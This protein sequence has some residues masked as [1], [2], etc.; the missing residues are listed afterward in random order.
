MYSRK[1]ILQAAFFLILAGM[2][3]SGYLLKPTDVRI[4]HYYES[5]SMYKEAIA[6]YEES[7]ENT[8][9][10]DFQEE[11]LVRISILC[12][13]IEDYEKF[14]IT[15]KRL[16]DLEYDDPKLMMD[17]AHIARDF[18]HFD[19]TNKKK[20]DDV[21][22]FAKRSGN[23]NFVMDFLLGNQR[24]GEA[25]SLYDEAYSSG[26]FTEEEMRKA[27]T[28]AR[29]TGDLQKRKMWLERALD[30]IGDVEV[31][32]ELFVVSVASGDNET[33]LQ[34][35]SHMQP[36]TLD[37]F[38]VLADFYDD[39]EDKQRAKACYAKAEALCV[40]ELA[41]IED[42]TSDRS[43]K[44]LTELVYLYWKNEKFEAVVSV[45]EDLRAMGCKDKKLMDDA[46]NA[47]LHLWR[48]NPD[49]RENQERIIRI[50][51]DMGKDDF[52]LD[53]LVQN[54]RVLDAL[55][56]YEKRRQKGELS[57]DDLKTAMEIA[58]WQNDQTVRE[59]WFERGINELPLDLKDKAFMDGAFQTSL[60]LWHENPNNRKNQERVIRIAEN[61]GKED[62]LPDFFVWNKRYSDALNIYEQRWEKGALAPNGLKKAIEISYW[63]N[64]R[65]LQKKWLKRGA[66]ELSDPE[67]MNKL[68]YMY[69][70]DG[71]YQPA[72][73]LY[74]RL[75]EIEPS[76]K[77]Y[78][79]KLA[80]LSETERDYR[81][82]YD[83]YKKAYNE[84]K[85][86]TY[87]Q[88]M[89][90]CAYHLDQS[91]YEDALQESV[92]LNPTEEN[93]FRLAS[94]YL[95]VK[96]DYR[97]ANKVLEKMVREWPLPKYQVLLSYS[98]L[99]FGDNSAALDILKRIPPEFN[100]PWGIQ[101]LSKHYQEQGKW[102]KAIDVIKD[103]I[104]FHPDD[105]DT[106][107]CLAYI[108]KRLNWT[109]K[110]QELIQSLLPSE[111]TEQMNK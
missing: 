61:M 110:Y 68:A 1:H 56:I 74:L 87:L 5:L 81:T 93:L 7:L 72:K 55:K 22:L 29:W 59:R 103:Y 40:Q 71:E 42:K 64:N 91:I 105:T 23:R 17:G 39:I 79:V 111:G 20:Q 78:L 31:I 89:V 92:E 30:V 36:K 25:L 62:Y 9:D 13:Y 35:A 6:A 101:F 107:L 50:A 96:K 73:R 49:N 16:L 21:I 102:N 84:T 11:I 37:D 51:G 66:E 48:K 10:Q 109:D 12:R 88:S 8:N 3:V 100:Q 106:L 57:T 26:N 69:L 28:L 94:F 53:F 97:E 47:S 18:W 76:N 67:I 52:L 83:S 27:V 2:L 65:A 75:K 4:A 41:A 80:Y 104:K 24:V 15:V 43:K 54:G 85:E 77:E 82:A 46:L 34:M 58:G 14:L 86:I 90:S 99:Q 33:A 45:V 32:K 108:Y 44:L 70:D 95:Y 63:Q 98:F 19:Q 38:H 60:R